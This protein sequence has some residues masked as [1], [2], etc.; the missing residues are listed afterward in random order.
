MVQTVSRVM[1]DVKTPL[2]EQLAGTAGRPVA[3]EAFRRARRTFLAGQRVDMG[4]LAR[5][6]GINRATLY[7]WVGSRDQLLVEIVWSLADRTFDGLLDAACVQ[8][9]RSRSASVLDAWAHAVIHNPGMRAF[10]EHEGELALRL[11]TTRA[12]DFQSRLLD[13]VRRLLTADLESGAVQTTIPVEDLTYVVVRIIESYVYLSL[14]TG[15]RPDAD[16]VGRVL[17]GLLPPADV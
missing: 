9:G 3:L 15:E 11:L 12:T 7:R 2:Q 8:P 17:H 16:R 6:L 1:S 4:E 5:D 10:V 13:I 14:I